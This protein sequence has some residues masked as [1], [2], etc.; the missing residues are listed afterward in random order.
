MND[1]LDNLV[2]IVLQ[3]ISKIDSDQDIID[4]SI[5][6]ATPWQCLLVTL[7]IWI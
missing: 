2:H 5:M 4:P 3:V 1:G 6:V 7:P